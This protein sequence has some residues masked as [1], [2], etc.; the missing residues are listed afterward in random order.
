M[1]FDDVVQDVN[2]MLS[3]KLL[4]KPMFSTQLQSGWKTKRQLTPFIDCIGVLLKWQPRGASF[5]LQ[6]E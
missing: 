3:F 6:P 2:T 1:P 5:P 4:L